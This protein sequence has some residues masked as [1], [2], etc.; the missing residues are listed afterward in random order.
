MTL[1]ASQA[2]TVVIYDRLLA[3]LGLI[4]A[5]NSRQALRTCVLHLRRKIERESRPEILLSEAGFGYRLAA[6]MDGLPYRETDPPQGEENW[7]YL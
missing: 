7:G 2:G 4:G 1:L 6:S 3:E 5:E